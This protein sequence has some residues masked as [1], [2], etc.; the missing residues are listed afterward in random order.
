MRDK[1]DYEM[2]RQERRQA[3]E[4]LL[5]NLPKDMVEIASKAVLLQEE[6]DDELDPVRK[7][8]LLKQLDLL[9]QEFL[10]AASTDE[11]KLLH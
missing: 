2:T 8:E 6:I 3:F 11:N 5:A 10:L 9:N 1:T 4:E 7:K